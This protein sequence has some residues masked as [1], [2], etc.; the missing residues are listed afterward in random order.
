MFCMIH[1]SLFTAGSIAHCRYDNNA[2]AYIPC[3]RDWIKKKVFQHLYKA[4][5]RDQ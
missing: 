5:E 1:S 4:T 2:K 3:N